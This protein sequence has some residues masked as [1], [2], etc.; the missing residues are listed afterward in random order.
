MGEN[1]SFSHAPACNIKTHPEN[2][3]II[4]SHHYN[5]HPST[6][7]RKQN[8]NKQNILKTCKTLASFTSK[9]KANYGRKVITRTTPQLQEQTNVLK[10]AHKN[11][12]RI[13][14]MNLIQNQ[15]NQTG[16]QTEKDKKTPSLS[17]Q[18][19]WREL[20]TSSKWSFVMP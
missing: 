6:S 13:I 8:Q 19:T 15:C 14:R 5:H 9:L 10:D 12:N 7:I 4:L 11:N 3:Y 17:V 2:T 18:L 16:N 1:N 20:S